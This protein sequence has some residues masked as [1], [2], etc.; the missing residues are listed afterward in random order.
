MAAGSRDTP[1]AAGMTIGRLAK[2][3]GVT[4][5]TVRYYERCGLLRR[6]PRSGRAYRRYPPAAVERI[7]FIK[8]VQSLGFTLEQIRDLL[9]LDGATGGRRDA[10]AACLLEEVRRRVAALRALERALEQRM[11]PHV[12]RPRS[13]V[14][15]LK[16]GPSRKA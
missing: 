5:E 9:E 14:A 3:A 11:R 10:A 16:P 12:R 4:V 15:T 2:V 1:A 8:L 6:P 7:G 13:V